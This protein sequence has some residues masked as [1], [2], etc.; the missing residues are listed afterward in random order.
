MR[1][2]LPL[3]KRYFLGAG[4]SKETGLQTKEHTETRALFAGADRSGG[5]G[6]WRVRPGQGLAEGVVDGLRHTRLT[7]IAMF[8]S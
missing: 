1:D 8:V 4:I 6:L 7:V 2:L 3:N 5:R